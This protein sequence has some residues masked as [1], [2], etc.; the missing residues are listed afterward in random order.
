MALN[1]DIWKMMLSTAHTETCT[2]M[3]V[4]YCHT[5]TFVRTTLQPQW[6]HLIILKLGLVLQ[7]FTLDNYY[8]G[9]ESHSLLDNKCSSKC[10]SILFPLWKTSDCTYF[11]WMFTGAGKWAEGEGAGMEGTDTVLTFLFFI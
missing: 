11:Y 1:E 3:S 8:F 2:N 5:V 4:K 9:W 10:E 6:Y 7:Q